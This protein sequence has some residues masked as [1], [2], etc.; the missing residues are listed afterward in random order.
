MIAVTVT[1]G[2]S[3]EQ[4]D[5]VDYAL[6]NLLG[7]PTVSISLDLGDESNVVIDTPVN[8]QALV[9]SSGNWVNGTVAAAYLGVMTGASAGA[10]GA[11]GAVPAPLAG[12]QESYLSGDATWKPLPST[13][14]ANASNL[15]LHEN[16]T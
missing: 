1:R 4:G 8:G 11:K 12:D 2:Y 16:F 6:L 10:D 15:Y 5:E 13:P 7:F 14:S 9:Y 3:F